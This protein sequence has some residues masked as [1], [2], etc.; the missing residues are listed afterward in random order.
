MLFQEREDWT[1]SATELEA[2]LVL[3]PERKPV[4]GDLVAMYCRPV[5]SMQRPRPSSEAEAVGFGSLTH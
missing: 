5:N 3:E 2:V 1:A 4:Y